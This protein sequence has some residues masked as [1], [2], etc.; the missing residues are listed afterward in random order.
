MTSKFESVRDTVRVATRVLSLA[1]MF[2]SE[3]FWGECSGKSRGL[4][5][6]REHCG[7]LATSVFEI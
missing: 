4:T 3:A 1:E 5:T 6:A 7:V 2:R